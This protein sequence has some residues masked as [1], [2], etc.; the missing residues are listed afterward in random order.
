MY[1][2]QIYKLKGEQVTEQ[3]MSH[4]YNVEISKLKEKHVIGL[5]EAFKDR[6]ITVEI[7]PPLSEE[8]GLYDVT[9]SNIHPV[10]MTPLMWWI[11]HHIEKSDYYEII[12]S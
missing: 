7:L 10:T 2:D 12:I 6:D 8:P 1:T 4:I 11:L 5:Q 3:K 9:I